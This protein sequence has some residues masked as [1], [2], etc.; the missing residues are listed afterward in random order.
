VYNSID[1]INFSTEL[2][3]DVS[4]TFFKRITSKWQT[5]YYQLMHIYLDW[6]SYPLKARV[7]PLDRIMTLCAMT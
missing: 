1:L 3:H 5:F 7:I 2:R 6:N 4:F